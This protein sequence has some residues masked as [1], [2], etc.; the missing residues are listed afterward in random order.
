MCA[1]TVIPEMSGLKSPLNDLPFSPEEILS[2][3][4]FCLISHVH[5]DHITKDCIPD[6]MLM[7]A[8]DE[9]DA[10]KLSEMGFT[11]V[12][13]FESDP[14]QIKDVTFIP[15]EGRHGNNDDVA[16]R[17]G[18]VSGFIV[19]ADDEKTLYIAGDTVWY[20]GVETN[21]ETYCPDIILVNCCGAE[22]PRGRLIMDV[23]EL[24]TIC[25]KAP[26]AIVIAAHPDSVNHAVYPRADVRK[27]VKEKQLTNALVPSDGETLEF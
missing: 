9:A 13:W 16:E 11:D 12:K 15:V 18:K 26:D 2:G 19:K 1:R 20:K 24:E 22:T 8:Q 5:P 4:D 10:A 3:V 17:M 21:L 14:M 6:E 27:F 7:I 23:D 25:H